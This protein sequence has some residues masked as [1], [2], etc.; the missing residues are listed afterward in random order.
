MA[1]HDPGFALR[2]GNDD[3][4]NL[5]GHD[6]AVGG[7]ELKVQIGHYSLLSIFASKA[8]VAVSNLSRQ[9]VLQ[10]PTTLPR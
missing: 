4:V 8:R 2:S 3:H 9:P 6:E 1:G 5:F 10:K 7:D